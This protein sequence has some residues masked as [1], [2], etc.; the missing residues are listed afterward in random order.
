MA[1]GRLAAVALTAAT[2][3][4]IYEAPAGKAPVCTVN[5]CNT[6]TEPV[7]VRL[8]ICS[9]P[10]P[11]DGE[12]VEYDAPLKAKGVLERGGIILGA[13]QK[14]FARASLAGV[15]VVVWGFE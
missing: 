7:D 9:G 13:G 1:S 6:S 11:V 8:A 5:I 10:A 14:I 4:L 3:G 12:Y 15:N 2:N